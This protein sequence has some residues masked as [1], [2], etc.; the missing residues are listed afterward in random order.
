MTRLNLWLL[1]AVCAASGCTLTPQPVPDL[2]LSGQPFRHSEA[3]LAAGRVAKP[4]NAIELSNWVSLFADPQLTG[5]VDFA[6]RENLEIKSANARIAQSRALFDVDK[7][8][9]LPTVRTSP[10]FDR[11]RVSGTVN[12]ALPQ[13]TLHNWAMPVDASY[14]VDLL[15][16]IEGRRRVG[17]RQASCRAS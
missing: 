17:A 11:S 10:G 2:A 5:L 9:T 15:G 8:Y 4:S 13:R 16:A 12:E 7:S 6:L 14:D 1:V 3:A